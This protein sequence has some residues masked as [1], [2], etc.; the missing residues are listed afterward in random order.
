MDTEYFSETLAP[1]DETT[2]RQNPRQD[3]RHVTVSVYRKMFH[4]MSTVLVL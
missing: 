3:Q 2:G 1:T 4:R